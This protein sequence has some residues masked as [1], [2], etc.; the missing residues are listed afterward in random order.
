MIQ[1]SNTQTLKHSNTQTH[2]ILHTLYTLFCPSSS[3]LGCLLG[4]SLLSWSSPS[5][6]CM[7]LI[8]PC[9]THYP[10]TVANFLSLLQPILESRLTSHIAHRAAQNS[11]ALCVLL[12][13]TRK[14][15]RSPLFCLLVRA[16]YSYV[17]S[18]T[19]SHLLPSPSF[20]ASCNNTFQTPARNISPSSSCPSLCFT[21]S[22]PS[23]T[24]LP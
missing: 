6:G 12:D 24:E 15:C 3:I 9:I 16:Q 22:P 23:D 13:E 20:R 19:A 18:L 7:D 2:T 21:R 11:L 17:P 10:I 14:R 4:C 1:Y 8:P 5:L